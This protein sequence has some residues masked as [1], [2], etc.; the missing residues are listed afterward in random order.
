MCS[1]LIFK[2]PEQAVHRTHG[3]GCQGAEGVIQIRDMVPQDCDLFF[4]PLAS[5]NL[6]Q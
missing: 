6:F 2:V 1:H 4:A 5:L 3:T